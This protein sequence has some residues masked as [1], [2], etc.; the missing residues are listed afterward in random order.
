MDPHFTCHARETRAPEAEP[1]GVAVPRIYLISDPGK[2]LPF[3]Q[4]PVPCPP[5]QANGKD[6]R[7]ADR[8]RLH[9]DRDGP[10]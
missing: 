9:Q 2:L 6:A 1:V 7:R 8:R 5:L 4:C 10:V 3:S